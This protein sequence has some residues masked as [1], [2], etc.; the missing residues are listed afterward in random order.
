MSP[1]CLWKLLAAREEHMSMALFI[2]GYWNHLAGGF[3][4]RQ[5][6]LDRLRARWGQPGRGDGQLASLYFGLTRDD[7]A[8]ACVDD[9]TWSDLEFPKIFAR[10]DTTVT[11]LGRQVLYRQLRT[12][13]DDPAVLATRFASYAWLRKHRDMREQIQLCLATLDRDGST[14]M[15][16]H[17]LGTIPESGKYHG[18]LVAWAVISIAI[19]ALALPL[20][21]PAAL[22]VPVL[23][24][25][26]GISVV[27]MG[28]VRFKME[29]LQRCMDLIGVSERLAAM[30]AD[31]PALPQLAALEREKASR[32]RCARVLRGLRVIVG[33]DAQKAPVVAEIVSAIKTLLLIEVLVVNRALRRFAQ[34]RGN[35]VKSFELVGSVDAAIAVA[36]WLESA[37]VHC[38]PEHDDGER[39]AIVGGQ[40]PLIDHGVG[41]DIRVH[42]KSVL[43]TG[44]NMAGKTTFIK[45]VGINLILGRNLGVC[46]AKSAVVPRGRVM[47]SIQN[48]HS[49]ESGKSHYFAEIDTIKSFIDLSRQPGFNVFLIDEPF[50]GTNTVER[51]AIARA[52]LQALSRNA[53][54]FV[55][56]HDVELQGLLGESH[57]LYHFE[58][59]PGV[60]GFFDYRL[61]PGASRNRNAIR[62]LD[63]IGFPGD[64]VAQAMA[65][66]S[67]A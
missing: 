61:K 10:M 41:N 58:E 1:H 38:Q 63:R 52:V 25:N 13:E 39:L 59:N 5:K 24:I 31:A 35:L 42:G 29:V 33:M 11:P 66:A 16:R 51:I 30:H 55:T 20:S 67:E 64:V 62:L 44:S 37:H 28:S 6:R 22:F 4:P 54:V 47:A 26:F 18:L 7:C 45:M 17:L 8:D 49:V 23:A 53:C 19:I 34:A 27:S 21:L 9:G 56:T 48:R 65:W 14:H 46:L 57:L 36:S 32:M 40:H 12:R 50:N 2:K 60:D 43:V 15:P 3:A